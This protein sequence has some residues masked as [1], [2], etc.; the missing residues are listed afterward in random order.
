ML[1][2]TLRKPSLDKDNIE[3]RFDELEIRLGRIEK[4]L[5]ETTPKTKKSGREKTQSN[6]YKGIVGGI[7][8]LI[9]NNFLDQLRSMREIYEELKKEGYYYPLQSVDKTLRADFVH[10]KKIL[11]R[12]QVDKVWKY[13]IRK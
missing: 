4:L 13:A 5:S 10:K 2:G 3:K 8:Y 1:S 12:Q 7:Q 9:D 11:T 6:S